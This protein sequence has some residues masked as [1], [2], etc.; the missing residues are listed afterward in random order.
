M[1]LVELAQHVQRADEYTRANVSNKLTVI[2]D[3]IKYLQ[4]QARK[5][6]EK[7]NTD[8]ALHQAACNMVKKPGNIYYLYQ[9]SSGQKYFSLLSPEEWGPSCPHQ[10]LGGFRL[11]ADMSWTPVNEVV[12]RDTDMLTINAIV[13][14]RTTIGT[15]PAARLG[16]PGVPELS[17]SNDVHMANGSC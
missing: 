4:E 15:A 6:L 17:Y 10:Y 7:A 13:G 3:Q 14:A 1:D 5:I 16:I 12:Q 9:R 8:A 11:E 2:V